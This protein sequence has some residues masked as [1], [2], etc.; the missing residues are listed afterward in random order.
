LNFRVQW[1]YRH[2]ADCL[3]CGFCSNPT[4]NSRLCY[5]TVLAQ[6]PK[7]GLAQTLFYHTGSHHSPICEAARL[8]ASRIWS[9]PNHE[10]EVVSPGGDPRP[11]SQS[12][13]AGMPWVY[14]PLLLLFFFSFFFLPFLWLDHVKIIN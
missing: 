1:T 3:N 7:I 10:A 9:E 12:G 14:R 5:V 11:K 13:L 8:L 4:Q 2:A 6:I